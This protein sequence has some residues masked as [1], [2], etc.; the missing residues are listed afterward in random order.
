MPMDTKFDRVKGISGFLLTTAT[1]FLFAVF[2]LKFKRSFGI[3]SPMLEDTEV[4][5]CINILEVT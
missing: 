3:S 1:Q 4:I 5:I 2:G